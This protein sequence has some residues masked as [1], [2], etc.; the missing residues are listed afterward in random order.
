MGEKILIIDDDPAVRDSLSEWLELQGF[1]VFTA[2]GG[3]QGIRLARAHHPDVIVCDFSMP[4]ED[5]LS[6]LEA[7]KSHA[8]TADIPFV[9]FTGGFGPARADGADRVVASYAE[10]RSQLLG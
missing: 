3:R 10:L 2:E 8:A 5:G 4:G 9:L 1:Q 6:V 7:L